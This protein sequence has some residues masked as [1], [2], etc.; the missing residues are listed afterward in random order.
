MSKNKTKK[1]KISQF[2]RPI[3]CEVCKMSGGSMRGVRNG[4]TNNKSKRKLATTYR[5]DRCNPLAVINQ[6]K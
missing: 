6:I 2:I 3:V 5:H 1:V 4:K